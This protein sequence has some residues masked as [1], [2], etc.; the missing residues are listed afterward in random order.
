MK[1]R[2]ITAVI[3]IAIFIPFLVFSR[4]VAFL[5]LIT[6]LSVCS[7]Y[8]LLGCVGMRGHVSVCIPTY[9]LSV[10]AIVT[11][12]YPEMDA[13]DFFMKLF[14]QLFIYINILFS[15]VVFSKGRIKFGD[16]AVMTIMMIYVLF[17]F[18]SLVRLRDVDNHGTFIFFLALIMPWVSDTFAYFCGRFFGRHK[19]I[20]EV[21]PKKT[22]E[23]AVGAVICTCLCSVAYGMLCDR[24]FDVYVNYVILAVMGILISVIA[25]CGDLIAS[26]VKRTY[27]IKDYGILLPGHGGVLDRFDST[28][29][30]TSVV[31]IFCLMF[32]FFGG[33]L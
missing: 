2:I 5:A 14:F 8:E 3:A 27:G 18:V 1:Q 19:L 31:Y 30:T 15:I 29:A 12:R 21:S 10:T 24:F 9:I 26:V 25:Q 13:S 6:F 33:N 22:V 11:T 28:I 20:P 32:P 7:A 17:G 23:G 4:S 16:A